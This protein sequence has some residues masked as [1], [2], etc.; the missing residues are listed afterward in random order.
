M[1]MWCLLNPM[2]LFMPSANS[3]NLDEFANTLRDLPFVGSI[4]FTTTEAHRDRGRD[5]IAEFK[6][7]DGST[8]SLHVVLKTSHLGS[9]AAQYL[10]SAI[11]QDARN[12]L[13]LA[14]YVGAPL[15]ASLEQLGINFV[16]RQGNCFLRIGKHFVARMQG[17]TPPKPP[18]R[19]KEMR[20]PAYQV[21]FALLAAPELVGATQRDIAAAAGTSRQPVADLLRRLGEERTIVKRGRAH[22]WVDGP[23]A[24]LLERWS[25]GY[26]STLRP[27]LL[28]GRFRLPV[29][30][31][32]E[33]EKWLEGR[34]GCVRFGGAAGAYRL[35]PHYRSALTVAHLGP[36]S[37]ETRRL[38]R[39][40]ASP[41]GDLVWMRHIGESSDHGVTA[42]TVHPLLVYAELIANPE[43]RT[44]EAAEIIREKWLSWSL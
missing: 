37:R 18:A 27:K 12:W 38:I 21:M 34:L 29:R 14:P 6:L 36:P 24:D 41:D 9:D 42:D 8:T 19:S 40:A 31:P 1:C 22:A 3:K 39:A 43:P 17:R 13:L 15:G 7:V 33:V 16:D 35:E 20:A 30:K 28:V 25:A 5:A 32:E 2:G 11:G 44:G 23:N 26:R 10:R 4:E